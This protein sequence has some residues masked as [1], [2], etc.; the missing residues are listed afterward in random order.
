MVVGK[1]IRSCDC[2]WLFIRLNLPLSIPKCR[3]TQRDDR[4]SAR[5]RQIF[6]FSWHVFIEEFALICSSEI[7]LCQLIELADQHA[8]SPHR[9]ATMTRKESTYRNLGAMR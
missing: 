4:M 5:I 2:L 8:K 1:V 6:D 7:L 9:I 3:K